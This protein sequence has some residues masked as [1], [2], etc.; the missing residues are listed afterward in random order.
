MTTTINIDMQTKKI[1]EL[2]KMEINSLS[3]KIAVDAA[4]NYYSID[5]EMQYWLYYAYPPADYIAEELERDRNN[6]FGSSGLTEEDIRKDYEETASK[7][8]I[9][10]RQLEMQ[11]D[12]FMGIMKM[13][14]DVERKFNELMNWS[15]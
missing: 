1:N 4:I 5:I 13:Y 10:I 11:R 15:C 14:P 6:V 3:D 2:K 12:Y 7:H 9:Y 8:L